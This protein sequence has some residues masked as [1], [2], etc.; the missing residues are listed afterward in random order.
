MKN[1]SFKLI[2]I[3]EHEI[4]LLQ[5][6]DGRHLHDDLVA[7]RLKTL[8]GI[9]GLIGRPSWSP[10]KRGTLPVTTTVTV[11]GEG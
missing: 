8:I 9:N 5:P 11:G 1:Q 4:L 3:A 2:S 7:M 10:G 6:D